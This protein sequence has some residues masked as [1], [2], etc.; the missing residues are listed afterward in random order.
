MEEQVRR[1]AKHVLAE[2]AAGRVAEVFARAL[3]GG[4]SEEYFREVLRD[5]EVTLVAPPEDVEAEIRVYGVTTASTPHC[6]E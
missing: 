4:M 2:L 1:T 3:P 5:Y 6:A